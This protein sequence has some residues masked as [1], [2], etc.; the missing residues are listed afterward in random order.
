MKKNLPFSFLP[1]PQFINIY[2]LPLENYT[3]LKNYEVSK[4]R[5]FL[6]NNKINLRFNFFFP[7]NKMSDYLIYKIINVKLL[8]ERL[9]PTSTVLSLSCVHNKI[10]PQHGHYIPPGNKIPLKSH[11][12]PSVPIPSHHPFPFFP[13]PSF[14]IPSFPLKC[15][16]WGG[17]RYLSHRLSPLSHPPVISSFTSSG[18]PQ[19]IFKC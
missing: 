15:I 17:W 13:I 11:P 16:N 12:F 1:G 5:W 10:E 8:R 4:F 3:P 2:F 18:Q 6:G 9:A 7:E 19:F 14:P